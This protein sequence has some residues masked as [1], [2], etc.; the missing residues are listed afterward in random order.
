MSP[1]DPSTSLMPVPDAGGAPTHTGDTAEPYQVMPALSDEEFAAL[2]ASLREHGCLVA[3]EYDEDGNV[4]DGHHRLRALRE[5]G[6]TNHPRVI[7]AGLGSH[8][9]KVAHALALNVHRRHLTP[10]QR[11]EAVMR[12]RDA[13]W[14]VRRIASATGIPKSTVARDVQGAPDRGPDA[15]VGD[16]G[17]TYQARRPKRP[18][19]VYVHSDHQ[20]RTAQTALDDL[21]SEVPARTLDLRGLERLRRAKVAE[22]SRKALHDRPG[23][24]DLPGRVDIRHSSIADLDIAAGSV[25][26]I[27]TDPPYMQAD[28]ATGGPWDLLGS[29]A[30]TWLKPGGLLLAYC[31]H[32]HLAR[33]ISVLAPYEADGLGFWWTYAVTFPN[34]N[35]GTQV[36]SRAITPSWRPVLAYRKTGGSG[37]PRYTSDPVTGDGK[38]KDS[39]HPWQQ[40]VQEAAT[41]IE[42][43]TTPGDLIV[44]P[45]IGSGTVA[46]AALALP[47]RRFIGADIEPDYVALAQR[48]VAAAQA[49]PTSEP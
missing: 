28:F 40:G 35:S 34:I 1:T 9:E 37:V 19:S 42:R 21:G 38:E 7:R 49:A 43:L 48:R 4:L 6:V 31:A 23:I 5:L 12:L 47:D 26:L 18:A 13:G 8:S 16:D 2:K 41:F 14:S 33:A 39:A 24:A 22:D 3:I 45:F 27:L 15:V 17:R 36:W 30:A 32:I 44:D 25:D 11:F 10:T 29:R 46:V 20:H